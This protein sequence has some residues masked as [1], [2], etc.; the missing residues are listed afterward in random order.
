MTDTGLLG[1]V[2]ALKSGLDPAVGMQLYGQYQADQDQQ[3][4]ERKARLEQ[5]N[6]LISGAAASGM[7]YEGALAQ[8]QALPGH[9][10]GYARQALGQLYPN[11]GPNAPQ[12]ALNYQG[13]VMSG[14][15]GS[16]PQPGGMTPPVGPSQM[17]YPVPDAGPQALSPAMDPNVALQQQAQQLQIAQAMAPPAPTAGEIEDQTFSTLVQGIRT[18]FDKGK[19]PDEVKSL[20]MSDPQFAGVFVSHYQ[21]IVRAFPEFFQV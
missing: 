12:P 7:P 14:P 18:L 15:V 5:Y 16:A 10:P 11:S 21:D 17:Q 20:I 6:Q 2:E 13:N 1:L 19:N 9:M 4:A 3:E 8:A